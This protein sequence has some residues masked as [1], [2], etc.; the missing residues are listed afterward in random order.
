MRLFIS[1]NHSVC[2]KQI[3]SGID[4]IVEELKR[5]LFNELI[6]SR[7]IV[8]ESNFDGRHYL[9]TLIYGKRNNPIFYDKF[10]F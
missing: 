9:Q 2:R 1:L 3:N 10:I 6:T 7:I 8:K 4:S 5:T